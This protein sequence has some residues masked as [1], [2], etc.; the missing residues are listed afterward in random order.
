MC[1]MTS[2]DDTVS[3]HLPLKPVLFWILLVL[4]DG[5][6]HGYGMLKEIEARTDGRIRLEPGNLYRYL[7]KLLDSALIEEIDAPG[8]APERDDRRRYYEITG[9]GRA[10]VGAEAARMRSLVRAAEDR[11]LLGPDGAAT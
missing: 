9:L 1:K 8:D 3:A 10:V 6:S 7:K 2:H 5:A 11:A 4:V